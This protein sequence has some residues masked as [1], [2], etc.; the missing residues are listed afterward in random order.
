MDER[1]D[2]EDVAKK[3]KRCVVKKDRMK[4]IIKRG[5][6]NSACRRRHACVNGRTGQWVSRT[7]NEEANRW[8]RG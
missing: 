3:K 1:N 2:K 8:V 7:G 6:L 5:S 4:G